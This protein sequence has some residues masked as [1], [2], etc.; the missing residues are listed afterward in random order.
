MVAAATAFVAAP[1]AAAPPKNDKPGKGSDNRNN[2]TSEK[3]RQAASAEDALRHLE[4]FQSIADANG[5]TRASGTPG[6]DLS[7]DY[8][9][10]QLT[11]AGY[12]PQ[13]QE[14]DFPFFQDLST[15]TVN[16]TAIAT[17]SFTFAGSGTLTGAKI[18]PVDVKI[19]PLPAPG[20]TSGCEAADFTGLDFSG[21]NDVALLQRGTCDFGLKALNAQVAGAEAVILFNEGQTGRTD[22]IVGTL[23]AVYGPQVTIPVI[24]ASFATGELLFKGGATVTLNADTI[25]ETRT[26]YNVIA[27]TTGGN[28]DN[29]VMV[30]AHLDSVLAGPGINDNGSGSAGILEIALDMKKVQPTNAIRFAWWGA[31]ELGLLGSRHYVTE[32]AKT[33]GEIDKIAL[34]LNFDM[35]ASPNYVRF[36]YDGDNSDAEGEGAGPAGSDVIEDVFTNYFTAVGLDSEGTDFSGRSDYGPFIAAGIDIPSGGLFTGAEGIKTAAQAARYGGVAGVA[37]D[38]CYHERCDALRNFVLSDADQAIYAQLGAAYPLIGNVNMRALEENIDAIAHSVITFAY[39]T[40]SVNGVVGDNGKGKTKIKRAPGGG[41]S[42]GAG[43]PTGGGLHDEHDHEVP[44][45]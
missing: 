17:G 26:T 8:I 28:P 24:G 4:A 15:L 1:A 31:E 32:L 9:V 20:S 30:G 36:V 38:P 10:Q 43:D 45:A 41:V 34:Y 6:Y 33:P 21:P 35:I 25:N 42:G 2:N 37:Y 11:A 40:E 14:F 12:T 39:S 3:L 44:A 7:K 18:I 29:V 16:G 13:V 19:P 27:Q 22:L 23:G 5:D